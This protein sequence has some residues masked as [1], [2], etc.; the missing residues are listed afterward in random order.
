VVV[1]AG[2]DVVVVVDGTFVDIRGAQ[3]MLAV[4]GVPSRVPNWSSMT[5]PGNGMRGHLTR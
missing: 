1:G 2:K 3:S 4:N 5:T